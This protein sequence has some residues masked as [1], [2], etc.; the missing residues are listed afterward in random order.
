MKLLLEERKVKL[1]LLKTQ[2]ET[3]KALVFEIKSASASVQKYEQAAIEWEIE[4][5]I[6]QSIERIEELMRSQ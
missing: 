6:G 5:F 1:E 2:L 4:K 3:S